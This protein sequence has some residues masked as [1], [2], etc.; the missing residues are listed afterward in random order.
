MDAT[1][2]VPGS[3]DHRRMASAARIFEES[4]LRE[5]IRLTCELSEVR[6]RLEHIISRGVC[7]NCGAKVFKEPL[8]VQAGE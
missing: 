1:N 8:D 2:P 6:E 5:V 7:P 3:H 4:E